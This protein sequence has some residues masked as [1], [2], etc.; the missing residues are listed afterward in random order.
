[1]VSIKD[2][3]RAAGVS[4]TTVSR[5]LRDS[6]EISAEMKA[7]IRQIAEEMG[8]R[9]SAVARS[10]VTRRTRVLGVVVT[11]LSDPFH[12]EVVQGIEMVAQEHG[13]SILFSLSHEDS[14]K[15]RAIVEM[16]AQRQVEGIIVAASRVG[17]RYL[18][19]LEELRI[20]IVLINSHHTGERVYSIAMDDHHGGLIATRYLTRLGHRRI[21][22]IS[23]VRGGETSRQRMAGYRQ[24]L[25]EVGLSF[26]HHLTAKGNGR[27]E[28]GVSAM[29]QLLALDPP[30]TAVF[31]YND[32]T[33]IGAL[34]AIL[35]AGLRVP[36]D[37]SLVGFDGL[38]E[39]TYVNPPLTTVEQPRLQMGRLAAQM[40]IGLLSDQSQPTR[41]ILQGTLIERS[42]CR[43]LHEEQRG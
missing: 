25:K 9:P 14:E 5:A 22:Y 30:P 24:A 29:Q 27:V 4:H 37:I 1:M 42:S 13:Y 31:C 16:M 10:L 20:P 7:R 32:L 34:K 2:I 43:A 12:T 35:Q 23:S 18:D 17:D 6:P 28:G 41:L 11:R 19:V 21:G 40:S 15:E 39:A 33:A 36:E 8:Y 3:A 38:V 26:D